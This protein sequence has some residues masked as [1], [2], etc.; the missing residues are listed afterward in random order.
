MRLTLDNVKDFIVGVLNKSFTNKKELD[1]FNENE[2]TKELNYGENKIAYKEYVDATF[3]SVRTGEYL[4]TM[5][6]LEDAPVGSVISF[7]GTKPP[8]HYLACD[9]KSYKINDYEHLANFFISHFGKVNYFGGD[10]IEEFCVPNLSNEF[11]R[12][13]TED[14]IAGTHQDATKHVSILNSDLST[15]LISPKSKLKTLNEDTS[16]VADT[17]TYNVYSTSSTWDAPV[18]IPQYYTSRPTNTAVMFCIKC[19]PTYYMSFVGNSIQVSIMNSD[20]IIMTAPTSTSNK[21]ISVSLKESIT[22]FDYIEFSTT[23]I[24]TNDDVQTIRQ[25]IKVSDV[26]YNENNDSSFITGRCYL[27]NESHNNM[28]IGIAGWFTDNN[29]FYIYNTYSSSSTWN[30]IRLNDIIGIKEDYR[31]NGI[32]A[33]VTTLFDAKG[34][35]QYTKGTEIPLNEDYTQYEA[36]RFV[37]TQNATMHPNLY[38]TTTIIKTQDI[39]GLK[40]EIFLGGYNTRYVSGHFNSSKNVFVIDSSASYSSEYLGILRIEGLIYDEY[41]KDA[42]YINDDVL[43]GDTKSVWSSKNTYNNIKGLLYDED[44]SIN[45]TWSSDKIQNTLTEQMGATVVC[46][47]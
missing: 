28:K 9:G 15:A 26:V 14:N 6:G 43:T 12:G 5:D 44:T 1:K 33:Q 22:E 27:Y 36:F 21:N 2:E 47:W 10:G 17:R 4:S 11:L 45:H 32:K 37:Y 29:N 13:S 24:Q 41:D 39:S 25:R 38:K 8:K 34:I 31:K 18:D 42:L 30:K 23:C 35:P 19:E 40:D 20:P 3:N 46:R 16:E 7:M